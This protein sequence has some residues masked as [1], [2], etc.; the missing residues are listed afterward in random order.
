MIRLKELLTEKTVKVK[1]Y[2][3]NEKAIQDFMAKLG[4]NDKVG[5]DV[6]DGETGEVIMNKGETKTKL[7]KRDRKSLEKYGNWDK[8]DSFTF[9]N[10]RNSHKEDFEEYFNVIYRDNAKGMSDDEKEMFRQGDYEYDFQLP[11]K[12]KRKDGKPFTDNDKQNIENFGE[13][14]GQYVL[15]GGNIHISV[16]I[17][18]KVADGEPQYI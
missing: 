15:S 4:A 6:I 5:D 9:I 10:D 12:I 18:K 1:G 2:F 8:W 11:S 7:A 16:G 14:Y 3:K 17:G 13:W